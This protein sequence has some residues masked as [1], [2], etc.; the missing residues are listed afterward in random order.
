MKARER[1]NNLFL[2]FADNNGVLCYISKMFAAPPRSQK[3]NR[4][5]YG[6]RLY[7]CLLLNTYGRRIILATTKIISKPELVT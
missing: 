2:N 6:A 4:E 7:N 3:I 5:V 1:G